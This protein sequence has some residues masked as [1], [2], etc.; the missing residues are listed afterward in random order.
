MANTILENARESAEVL[1]ISERDALVLE[2]A[3]M[4]AWAHIQGKNK[5]E[6]IMHVAGCHAAGTMDGKTFRKC[7]ELIGE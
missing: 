7:M 3:A 1:G 4:A 2:F 6:A 5:A